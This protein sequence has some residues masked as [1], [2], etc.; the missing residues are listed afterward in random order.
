M[1]RFLMATSAIFAGAS[2]A[3]AGG[4]ERSAQ[5]VAILFEQGSYA[6]LSFGRFD[7]TVEGSVGGGL[8]TSGDMAPSYNSWSLG[9]KMDIGDRMAFAMILDQP[10]GANVNY[11]TG[12]GYPLGGSTAKLTSNAITALLRYKFENNVSVYGGL[13][14]ETVHGEVSLPSVGAYTLDTNQD[15]ELGYVVGVSWEKPEIAARVA[16]TYNSAITHSL[17]SV[18]RGTPTAGFETEVPQ[19][20]NLEFQTGIA[21]NTLL[22]GS[23]RWVDWTS[24][25]IDPPS[26]PAGLGNLVDYASDRVTYNLGI[27]RRFNENWS[28]AITLGYEKA[29]GAR[30][31]NLGPTDGLKSIGL[32]ATYT[33]DSIKITGGIRYVDLGDATTNPPIGGVFTDNSGVGIGVKVGWSF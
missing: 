11:P 24:F 8:V 3:N 23:I 28:G 20:L 26:Y 12:T 2:G 18:E 29:D 17:E 31:G 4:V 30:T 33:Q 25:I 5:S 15:S 22:F 9:Y 10:I 21:K 1:K 6:E 32:A 13:R 16:L 19:S 7:P 14:Y 27:G